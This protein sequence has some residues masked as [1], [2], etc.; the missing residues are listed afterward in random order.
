[1]K[2][3]LMMKLQMNLLLTSTDKLLPRFSLQHQIDLMGEQYDSVN[4]SPQLYQIHM[5]ITE[6]D[7]L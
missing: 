1:M 7:W 6:E 5:F 2:R 3:L 4:S